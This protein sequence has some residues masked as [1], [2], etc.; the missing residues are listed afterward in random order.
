M[1]YLALKH[2]APAGLL[3]RL[4]HAL[5]RARLVTQ[6][7]HGGIVRGDTLMHS[8]L[9]KGLHAE[10]FN[11]R[12]W[13]LFPIP[14]QPWHEGLFEH[15]KGTPYDAFSQLA[16]A[17]PWRISDSSRMYCYEWQHLWL[18]GEKRRGRIVPELLLALI[19]SK[20]IQSTSDKT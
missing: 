16:F 19:A 9:A 2:A 4:F 17:L 8:T 20:T 3:P 14:D 12:G 15:Y 11:P 7:P 5:T 13:H 18:T 6:Y 10:P 1:T